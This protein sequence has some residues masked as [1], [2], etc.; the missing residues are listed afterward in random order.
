MLDRAPTRD[1]EAYALFLEARPLLDTRQRGP[2]LR[3]EELLTRAIARD[4]AFALAHA[5]L[6]ECYAQR[7]LSWWAG[8]EAADLAAPRA[9][10]ALDLEP[11]L[12]EAHLVVAMIHRLRG[13]ADQLPGALERVLAMDP[14]NA[15]AQEWIGW[16][17]MALGQ[18]EKALG[19]LERLCVRHP[20]RTGSASFLLNCYDMLHRT[21]DLERWRAVCRERFIEAVRRDPDNAYYRSLLA[22]ALIQGG[23]REAGIEQAE[24]AAAQALD[25]GRVHYNVACAFAGAGLPERAIAEL[26]EGIRNVPTYVADWPR[27]DPDLASLHD[28]PEFVRLFGKAEP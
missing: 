22:G 14:E 5:A 17:Y 1:A 23:E 18:P 13:E 25:D 8:L 16:S 12:L 9:R 15:Q 6:G 27:R 10:R 11:D 3:A 21:A 24:R 28:H 26:K 20:E 19:I 4:P 7:A 2:N